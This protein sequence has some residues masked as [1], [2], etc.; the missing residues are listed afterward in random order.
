MNDSQLRS[1]VKRKV[2]ARYVKDP[3]TR[4]VDELGLRHGAVPAEAS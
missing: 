3:D 1:A 4:I 2:L